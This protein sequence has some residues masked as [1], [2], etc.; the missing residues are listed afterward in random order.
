M[1]PRLRGVLY[2]IVLLCSVLF[3]VSV[4]LCIVLLVKYGGLAKLD[5]GCHAQQVMFDRHVYYWGFL[6]PMYFL[7][8]HALLA[9]YAFF[10]D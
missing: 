8:I 9:P 10:I 2:R 7:K 5:Q 4:V 1:P 3:S 6:A